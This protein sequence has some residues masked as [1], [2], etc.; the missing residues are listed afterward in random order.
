V[1]I[2]I[3]VFWVVTLYS[4][5]AI[6]QSFGGTYCCCLL[7]REG[8]EMWA[9]L[10]YYAVWNSNPLSMFWDSVSVRFSRVNKSKKKKASKKMHGLYM[11]GLGGDC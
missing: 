10:G 2:H 8:Y 11:E 1:K 4:Q 9:L 5:V 3:V 6:Y 7:K